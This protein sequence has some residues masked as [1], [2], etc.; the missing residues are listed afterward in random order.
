MTAPVR[1]AVVGAGLFTQKA[2]LPALLNLTDRFTIQVVC[3]RSLV[4]A[5][6]LATAIPHP[7]D[8][9]TDFNA[10]LARPDIDAVDLIVPIGTLPAMVEA[11][12]AAGKHVISEKPAAPDVAS[13]R[14]LLALPRRSVWMVAENCR[15]SESVRRAAEIVQSGA[16]GKPIL[17][18]WLRHAAV[19]KGIY[20]STTWRRDNSFPGGFL[21]DGGVH[22]AAILRTILG[23]ITDVSA[24][25]TQARPDLPPADTMSAAIHFAN[26]CLGSYIVTYAGDSAYQHLI[27]I[28]GDNGSLQVDPYQ[29]DLTGVPGITGELKMQFPDTMVQSELAD[30]A[31]AIQSGK[32]P[33]ST[34]EQAVQ[35]VAVFE[36]MLQSG[37][38]DRAV[39][40]EK[41][42]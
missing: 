42:V 9:I 23:E 1:L 39:S 28:V 30:F 40:P 8:V 33:R 19:F 11:A 2:H 34:P 6:K 36:A 27:T 10:V 31:D 32:T 7:V 18:Q 20:Y 37:Q 12:L 4:S 3:S 25:M 29:L 17:C 21:L 38:T 41:I 24:Y 26:G 5:D 13:G 15:Y 35:D 14:R 22:D 16:I